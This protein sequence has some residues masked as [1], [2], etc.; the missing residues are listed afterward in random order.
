[1]P[2][3]WESFLLILVL[4]LLIFLGGP[5]LFVFAVVAGIIRSFDDPL[6]SDAELDKQR[7]RWVEEHPDLIKKWLTENPGEKLP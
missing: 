7:A 3:M 6:Q 4:L 5:M 2:E 1:M